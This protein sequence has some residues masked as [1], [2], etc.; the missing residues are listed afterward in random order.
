MLLIVLPQ[1]LRMTLP[2]TVNLFV[3]AFKDT[4]MVLIVGLFDFV[5]SANT[6][7]SKDGWQPFFREVYILIAVVYLVA[8]GVIAR[9]GVT[10]E[11]Q[12]LR[13]G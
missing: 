4:S 11:R 1:A 8:T 2:A 5:A 7:Y 10:F 3:V 9:I 12:A 13:H 6:T